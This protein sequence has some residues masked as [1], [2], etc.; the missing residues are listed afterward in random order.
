MKVILLQ[1]VRNLGKAGD[2]V[3]ASD[4]YA[5]NMLFPKGLAKEATAGNIKSIENKKAADQAMREEQKKE[6]EE[7]KKVLANKRV[8]VVSKGGGG[9]AGKLFG[10]VTNVDI[11]KA[12]KDQFDY[13]IDKK[14]ISIPKPIK[15]VGTHS[16]EAHLFT[17][18]N[19]ELSIEVTI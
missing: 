11:A 9:E 8:K 17:D 18:V 19:V 13:D 5:R 12:I 10:A 15:T 16:A 3:K 1:D 7:I 2:V 4:G 14:K 6:A